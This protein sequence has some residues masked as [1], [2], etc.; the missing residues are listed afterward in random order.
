MKILLVCENYYPHQGGAEL[1]FRN[2]AERFVQHG[3][4]V[5]VLTQQL[6][7]TA[8]Q[9][10]FN[11]VQIRRVP[12]FR[13]RYV[14]TFSS[15]GKA[16]KLARQH[17]LIQ[18]TTFNGAPSAWLAA[19]ITGKPVVLTVHEVW[20][21]KWKEIAEFPWLKRS[22]HAL[23]ERTIYLLPY[24]KYICVSQA[25][26]RDLLGLGIAPPK[27][28]QIYNGFDDKLW[29]LQQQ[30]GQKERQK[31]RNMLR[32]AWGIQDTVQDTFV[33][34]SWGRPGPSKGF[35]YLLQAVPLITARLPRS[36]LFLL[37]GSIE[38]SMGI[39][40]KKYQQLQSLIERLHLHDQVQI[41]TPFSLS[42]L[43]GY[44]QAADG[45]V[46][47]SLSEGFGYT[48]LEALAMKKPVVVSDAGS[49]PEIVGG[50]YQIFKSKDVRDLAEKVVA[51]ASGQWK[52][53]AI[54]TFTW[55]KCI[56]SYLQ[57]YSSVLAQ[58]KRED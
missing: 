57:V 56:Q 52:K 50:K 11:G 40:R 35:E 16:I 13:S 48:T 49:L 39:Y 2:L 31:K 33:Y 25:T 14:F 26:E 53:K 43:G 29:K 28:A 45:V 54:P 51:I 7:D 20:L 42:E 32:R 37:L 34:L 10:E 55:E 18:T 22:I 24:D 36:K 44:L 1:L 6:K 19:R 8:I 21:H 4:T 58:K 47:P 5:T 9:E 27:V 38:N 12:S 15:L 41:I 30:G 46:I 3:H 17:D 23:L